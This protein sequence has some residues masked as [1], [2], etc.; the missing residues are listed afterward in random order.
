MMADPTTNTIR[1]E[2]GTSR[3]DAAGTEI[4]SIVNTAAADAAAA[5]SELPISLRMIENRVESSRIHDDQ[6]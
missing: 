5:I 1:V 4:A 3:I 2:D 6:Q